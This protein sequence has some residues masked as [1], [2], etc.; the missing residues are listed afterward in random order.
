MPARSAEAKRPY[1]PGWDVSL[2][3]PPLSSSY[4]PVQVSF[5][6]LAR[7]ACVCPIPDTVIV[8]T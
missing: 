3:P 4:R 7:I 1:R 5:D 6:F 2:S 8:S